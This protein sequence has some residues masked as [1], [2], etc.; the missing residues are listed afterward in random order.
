MKADS[1]KRILVIRNDKLGDFML[2]WPSFAL[3]KSNYPDATVIALVPEYTRPM[4]ESCPWIDEVIADTARKNA[5]L[6]AIKLASL[7]RRKAPTASISLF[8]EFRTALALW[9]ARVPTRVAPATKIAQIFHNVRIKQRRSESIKPEYE[10]NLDLVRHFLAVN[11]KT[12]VRPCVPPCLAIDE[13]A[14]GRRRS[15]YLAERQLAE[16]TRLVIIHPGTGG[17]AINLSVEQYARLAREIATQVQCHFIITAGPGEEVIA[18]ELKNLLGGLNPA[19]HESRDGL[20]EFARFI[21]IADLFISGSTG[22]LHIAGAANVPTLAF[23][24]SR[25]SA[26][27]LRWQTLNTAD[28]RLAYSGDEQGMASIDI[29]Q[30]AADA[31][32]FLDRPLASN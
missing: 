11:G 18:N 7:I 23:Y 28:R 26:T 9:L 6:D 21:S 14:T 15:D 2:A 30:A 29:R 17:S 16:L 5:L 27:A 12:D 24:P 19:V 20:V 8:S 13:A 3:I 10:Y 32:A 22:P 31:A 25:K 1:V 4:A